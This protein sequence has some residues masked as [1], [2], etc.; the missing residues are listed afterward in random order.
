[1]LFVPNASSPFAINPED[2]VVKIYG[3]LISTDYDFLFRVVDKWGNVV[4]E[5]TSVEEMSTTGWDGINRKTG[6]RVEFGHFNYFMH[7]VLKTGKQVHKNGSILMA[8]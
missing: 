1:M 3:D 5:T 2:Q 4:Y 8:K 7:G 6:S